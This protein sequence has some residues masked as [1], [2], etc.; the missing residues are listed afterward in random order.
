MVFPVDLWFMDDVRKLST[1]VFLVLGWPHSDGFLS[2][3]DG[4]YGC[5][6][7]WISEVVF[8]VIFRD[9][10]G[11]AKGCQVMTGTPWVAL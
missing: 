8:D 11:I 1:G 9:S 10:G 7:L 5:E 4:S 2:M 6:L 3:E